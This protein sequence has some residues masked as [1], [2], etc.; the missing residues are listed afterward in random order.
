MKATEGRIDRVFV[1][2]LEDGDTIPDCIERFA[3]DN[4]VLHGHVVMVGG[5]G[6]GEIIVGPRDSEARPPDP[7]SLPLD[8]AHEVVGVGVLAPDERGRPILHIHAA[9]GRSGQ[10]VTGCLRKGVSTWL[11]G[12]V[13]L[14]EISGVRASRVMDKRNE[15]P[16]LMPEVSGWGRGD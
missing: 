2:R 3:R 1:I 15:L 9:L 5:I 16:L 12:E 8:G 14:Y 7:M 13:I 11:V 6:K 10:T 4:D